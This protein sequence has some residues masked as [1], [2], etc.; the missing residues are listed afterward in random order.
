MDKLDLCGWVKNQ[1]EERGGPRV[2]LTYSPE[3]VRFCEDNHKRAIF[4]SQLLFST[5]KSRNDGWV[6]KSWRDW[7]VE[8]NLSKKDVARCGEYLL[9]RGLIEKEVMK[10]KGAPT[11]HYRVRRAEFET[12]FAQFLDS[13]QMA[14]WIVQ[15]GSNAL[16]ANGAMESAETAQSITKPKTKP[17][18]KPPSNLTPPQTP[19]GAGGRREGNSSSG[20]KKR[21]SYPGPGDLMF[22]AIAAASGMDPKLNERKIGELAYDLRMNG[23]WA[24]DVGEFAADHWD[25]DGYRTD[26]PKLT[27]IRQGIGEVED[28]ERAESGPTFT[29]VQLTPAHEVQEYR[30]GN[31]EAKPC[32]MLCGEDLKQCHTIFVH[33]LGERSAYFCSQECAAQWWE[34]YLEYQ[35]Q[36]NR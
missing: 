31:A 19:Q 35:A 21:R 26:K 18:T 7:A 24:S 29:Q 30:W 17:P 27:A 14:Q 34:R 1:I 8:A 5:D 9:S 2:L 23:Y 22:D 28:E 10:A 13:R 15:D 33:A 20:R 6:Y 12:A 32:Q 11:N 16:P 4:L 36:Q 3:L 25:P